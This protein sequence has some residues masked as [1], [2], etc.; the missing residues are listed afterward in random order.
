M[1]AGAAES[2]KL[3]T[4]HEPFAQTTQSG[5]DP[6]TGAKAVSDCRIECGIGR[7]GYV[8][9]CPSIRSLQSPQISNQR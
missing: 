9:R 8:F 5:A 7:H 6:G 3:A 1:Q 2:G 4:Q